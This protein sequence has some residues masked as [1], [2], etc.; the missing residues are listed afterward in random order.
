MVWS[1]DDS[2]DVCSAVSVLGLSSIFIIDGSAQC[3][4][5]YYWFDSLINGTLYVVD[6]NGTVVG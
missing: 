6:G 4:V 2:W 3:G 1:W 5:L